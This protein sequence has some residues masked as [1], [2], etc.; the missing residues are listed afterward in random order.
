L[1][2]H[3][4][5]QST[6]E[7]YWR[8]IWRR[9]WIVVLTVFATTVT[10][11]AAS[12][13]ITPVYE[14]SATLHVKEPMPSVL[15]GDLVG[16]GLSAIST[17]EEIN[18]Q[19]EILKSRSLLEGVIAAQG[20]VDRYGIGKELGAEERLQSAVQ[21]LRK[22]MSVSNIAN[23]RLIRIWLARS[24]TPSPER[25][26]TGTSNRRAARRTPCFPSFRSRWNRSAHG[27]RTRKR[28]SWR[29]SSAM[30]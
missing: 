23:T 26:L 10:I 17:K 6:L 22:D 27:S 13:L 8:V 24:P 1:A 12:Y 16:S 2:E 18:T 9:K 3:G 5:D 14:A 21:R 28:S 30:A 25:S 29:T 15:G 19:I 11:V 20:L 7:H 4:D